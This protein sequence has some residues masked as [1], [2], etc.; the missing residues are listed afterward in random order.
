MKTDDAL[1]LAYG[2]KVRSRKNARNDGTVLGARIGDLLVEKGDVGYVVS[3]TPF[4]RQSYVYG[5]DFLER[6]RVVGMRA[7]ELDILGEPQGR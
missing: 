4:L 3:I 6:G 2:Q 1:V 5:V 7:K